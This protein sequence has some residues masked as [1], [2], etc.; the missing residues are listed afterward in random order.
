MRGLENLGNTCG[1]NTLI[2]C[3]GHSPI[4]R[5][6][7][8]DNIEKLPNKSLVEAL[9]AI[10]K[11]Q[12]VDHCTI[13]PHGFISIFF[14]KIPL[15]TP[16]EQHD[17]NELWTMMFDCIGKELHSDEHHQLY[18]YNDNNVVVT[19]KYDKLIYKDMI[20][21]SCDEMFRYN[22]ENACSW[23]DLIQ[24]VQISQIH[25]K[26]CNFVLQN[27]E[28]WAALT[29]EV[30]CTRKIVDSLEKYMKSVA[31]NDWTCDQCKKQEQVSQ[32]VR[33]WKL[34]KV[35]IVTLKRFEYDCVK[36][37][38]KKINNPVDIPEHIQ[39][40]ESHVLGSESRAI[41]EKNNGCLDYKLS[42]VGLHHGS[43]NYGHYTAIGRVSDDNWVHYDDINTYECKIE[44]ILKSNS[45][46]YVLIYTMV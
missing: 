33:F 30:P 19:H 32:T 41:M 1:L 39:F 27:I 28:P 26:D 25:C 31:I 11:L 8:L 10:I 34:P 7:L 20:V 13:A 40:Y 3:V 45:A 46:A 44:K 35:L 24:G 16:G 9:A 23:T 43:A 37:S 6:W 22:H 38:M 4:L 21:K 42:S 12:W 2:Q 18:K 5:T 36:N 29:I 15:F 17:L 14:K